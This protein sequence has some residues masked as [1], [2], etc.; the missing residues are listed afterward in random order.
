MFLFVNQQTLKRR[1]G[2]IIIT[3]VQDC[4]PGTDLTQDSK[5]MLRSGS[6]AEDNGLNSTSIG[7]NYQE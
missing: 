1:C 2:F 5:C 3:I 7:F 6:L 4:V